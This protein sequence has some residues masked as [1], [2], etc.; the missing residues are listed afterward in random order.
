MISINSSVE[1]RHGDVN[2]WRTGTVIEVQ[3]NPY[4]K[5]SLLEYTYKIKCL[6]TT[7]T[8]RAQDV[9]LLIDTPRIVD[10]LLNL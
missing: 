1:F 4:L 3:S 5:G 6:L 9:R 10:E 8:R 7:H 2:D